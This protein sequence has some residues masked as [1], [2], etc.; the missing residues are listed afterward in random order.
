MALLYAAAKGKSEFK[1]KN[2]NVFKFKKMDKD[3][4]KALK[5]YLDD[6]S[7]R[8]KAREKGKKA[9]DWAKGKWSDFKGKFG[10]MLDLDK[11][12]VN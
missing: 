2:G 1:F 4:R 8:G 3:Q 10:D 6:K 5:G 7:S 12:K 9:R 11:H